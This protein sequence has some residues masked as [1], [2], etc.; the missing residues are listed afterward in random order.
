MNIMQIHCF[1]RRTHRVPFC[2]WPADLAQWDVIQVRDTKPVP[3][4]QY[5]QVFGQRFNLPV[6]PLAVGAACCRTFLQPERCY[7]PSALNMFPH[8]PGYVV[9]LYMAKEP[10]TLNPEN[11]FGPALA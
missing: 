5:L 11:G 8:D 9:S 2:L 6:H 1:I 4:N 10:R 7:G 3:T